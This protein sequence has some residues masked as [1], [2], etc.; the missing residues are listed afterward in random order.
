[1]P[2]HNESVTPSNRALRAALAAET[3]GLP[4]PPFPAASSSAS[5]PG[6]RQARALPP[7]RAAVSASAAVS[8]GSSNSSPSGP[9][10]GTRHS[11]HNHAALSHDSGIECHIRDEAMTGTLSQLRRGHSMRGRGRGSERRVWEGMDVA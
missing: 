10:A 11:Y 4:G 5:G 9:P 8:G 6:D 2:G 1:M 7:S 3:P